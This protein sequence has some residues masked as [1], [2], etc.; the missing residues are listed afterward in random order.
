MFLA[1]S[2]ICR[3]V[4][5]HPTPLYILER[6]NEPLVPYTDSWMFKPVVPLGAMNLLLEDTRGLMVTSMGQLA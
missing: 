4:E 3:V 5:Q 6:S 1:P 2:S